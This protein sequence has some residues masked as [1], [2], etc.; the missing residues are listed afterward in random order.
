[1]VYVCGDYNA[2]IGNIEDAIENIYSSILPR[3]VIDN[4]VYGYGEAVTDFIKDVSLRILSGRLD[5]LNDTLCGRLH[6]YS[7]RLYWQMCLLK[8]HTMN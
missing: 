3:C 6:K 8:E 1:M 7:T 5:P 4:L 2:W